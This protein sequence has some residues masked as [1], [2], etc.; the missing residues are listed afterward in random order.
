[1]RVAVFRIITYLIHAVAAAIASLATI[2][3]SHLLPFILLA[4][5]TAIGVVALCTSFGS[6]LLLRRRKTPGSR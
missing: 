2:V 4:A 5:A 6:A 1:M 3:L